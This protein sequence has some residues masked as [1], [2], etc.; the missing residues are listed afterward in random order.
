MPRRGFHR[1]LSATLGSLGGSGAFRERHKIIVRRAV[2]FPPTRTDRSRPPPSAQSTSGLC[3]VRHARAGGLTRND[4]PKDNPR[5]SREARRLA[6]AKIELLLNRPQ[7]R[8]TRD[9]ARHG[10]RASR[11]QKEN[12]QR[13]LSPQRVVCR[14]L[15]R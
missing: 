5:H 9:D 3:A 14:R 4:G 15:V 1:G 2:W 13:N 6:I 11:Q 12:D 10:A 7:T 8:R